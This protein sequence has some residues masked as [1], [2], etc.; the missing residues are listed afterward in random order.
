M[1]A[2][3]A[4]A[5]GV[6]ALSAYEAHIINVT[7]K[8][9][10][11]LYVDTTPIDFGTVF[12][13]EYLEK[14]IL[15]SLS[16]SF[17]AQDRLDDVKYVIKQKPKPKN[18]DN[19]VPEGFDTWHDYCAASV[20]DLDNC[21]PTLCPYLSKHK[22]ET[23]N[24]MATDQCAGVLADGTSYY[25]CGIDAFHN[26]DEMAYGYLVQSVNDDADLWVIDLDVPCFDGE[27][28]QDWT[29]FGW[30]LPAQLNGEVFGCDLWIEVYDFSEWTGS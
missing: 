11:A 10:N 22:A 14:E 13:Q 2:V 29:H 16:D 5:G 17:L 4:V 27:C 23:D 19:P 30:E 24:S 28:A 1:V 9:E 25:D 3:V 8:I 12:P 6:A 7:A 21:Y 15:I 18:P 26:P 20:L